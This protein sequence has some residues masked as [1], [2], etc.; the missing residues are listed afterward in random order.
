M[1][2]K[3]LHKGSVIV[4]DNVGVLTDQM[5]EYLDYVRSSRNYK[6]EYIPFGK[7]GVEVSVK[8]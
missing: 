3:K 5:K 2:E 1:V 7:D 8:L 6:S 4:A